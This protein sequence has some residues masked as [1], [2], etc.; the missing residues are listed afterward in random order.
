MSVKFCY[1]IIHWDKQ[2]LEITFEGAYL[3]SGGKKFEVSGLKRVVYK[4]EKLYLCK[5]KI[6]IGRHIDE[7]FKLF[8]LD[9]ERASQMGQ[10]NIQLIGE[11]DKGVFIFDKEFVKGMSKVDS[12]IVPKK[13]QGESG[14]FSKDS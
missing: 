2:R 12:K 5:I 13:S 3:A 11:N 8:V 14:K 9:D 1:N 10:D 7:T 4:G 6:N